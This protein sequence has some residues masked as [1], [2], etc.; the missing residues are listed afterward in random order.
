MKIIT[1]T[2]S[3]DGGGEFVNMTSKSEYTVLSACIEMLSHAV[4]V[5][6]QNSLMVSRQKV[7]TREW[8]GERA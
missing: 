6:D 7:R 1:G 4:K 5:R 8:G 2:I 3:H